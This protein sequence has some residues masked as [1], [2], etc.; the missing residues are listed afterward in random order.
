[1]Q[2]YKSQCVAIMICAKVVN[3]LQTRETHICRQHLIS[4]YIKLSKLS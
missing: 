4:L 1:M 2:D 3:I